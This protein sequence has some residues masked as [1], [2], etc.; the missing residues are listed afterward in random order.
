VAHRLNRR[1]CLAAAGCAVFAVV[2][3]ARA[4][5]RKLLLGEVLAPAGRPGDLVA[6]RRVV[7]GVFRELRVPERSGPSY[8]LSAALV[9]FRRVVDEHSSTTTCVVSATLRDREGGSLRAVLR[10]NV[11]MHESSQPTR[12]GDLMAMQAAVRRALSRVREAL[13]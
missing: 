1:L 4:E 10:G 2:R 13:S 9:E 6:F 8:V 7:E 11:R 3:P 5:P 12:A